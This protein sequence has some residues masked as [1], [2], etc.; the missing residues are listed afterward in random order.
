MRFY[1]AATGITG[2]RALDVAAGGGIDRVFDVVAGGAP[3]DSAAD[4]V[5]GGAS[6][7]ASPVAAVGAAGAAFEAAAPSCFFSLLYWRCA[8]LLAPPCFFWNFRGCASLSDSARDAIVEAAALSGAGS[9]D[10]V[11]T[12]AA[13]C[14]PSD[15]CRRSH[16]FAKH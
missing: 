5:A 8:R 9:T 15:P 12:S 2:G 6:D 16:S 4:A 7:A 3:D 11:A 1:R 13:A 10:G 14:N